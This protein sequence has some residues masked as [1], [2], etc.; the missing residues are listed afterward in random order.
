MSRRHLALLARLHSND[1]SVFDALA[2][3]PPSF[4]NL[5]L[6]KYEEN[7]LDSNFWLSTHVITVTLDIQAPF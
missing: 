2:N 7:V 3:N 1:N 4:S 5:I 6:Q